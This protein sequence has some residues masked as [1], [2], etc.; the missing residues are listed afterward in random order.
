M[1]DASIWI[2]LLLA[3]AIPVTGLL[4]A[5]PVFLLLH[6]LGHAIPARILGKKEVRIILGRPPYGTRIQVFGIEILISRMQPFAGKTTYTGIPENRKEAA[7]I[8]GT[9][10]ML[11]LFL[12]CVPILIPMNF[13]PAILLLIGGAWLAN[14]HI[15]MGS[16]LPWEKKIIS[17]KTPSSEEVQNYPSDALAL[18]RYFAHSK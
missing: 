10:P 15:A 2:T 3:V 7:L 18:I 16:C 14:T 6:E 8:I 4:I 9:A 13:P 1:N 17:N 12:S 5:Y 11:S